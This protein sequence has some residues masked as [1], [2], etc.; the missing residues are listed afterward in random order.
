MTVHSDLIA[1]SAWPTDLVS[2]GVVAS[3]GRVTTGRRPE[4]V[5]PTDASVWLERKSVEEEGK[6]FQGLSRHV[7]VVHVFDRRNPGE[8]QS[9]Y[10]QTTSVEAKLRTIVSRYHGKRPLYTF[11]SSIVA[12]EAVEE[13]TDVDPEDREVCEGTVRVTFSVKG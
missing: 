2:A 9:G 4:K 1:T 10:A 5:R 3:T 13:S 7:Y 11:N 6:G 8:N 12:A